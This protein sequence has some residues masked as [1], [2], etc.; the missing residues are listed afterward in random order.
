M[1][2]LKKNERA[3]VF[4]FFNSAPNAGSSVQALIDKLNAANQVS[5]VEEITKSVGEQKKP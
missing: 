5:L 3:S 2:K 1:K 4:Y